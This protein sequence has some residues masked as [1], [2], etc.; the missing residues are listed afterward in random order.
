MVVCA[1]Q[2]FFLTEFVLTRFHCK[3]KLLNFSSDNV[4]LL[5]LQNR[6]AMLCGECQQNYSLTLS[7]LNCSKCKA[8]TTGVCFWYLH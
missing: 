7:S 5:C 1:I 2:N 3:D 8:T 6:I 4:D